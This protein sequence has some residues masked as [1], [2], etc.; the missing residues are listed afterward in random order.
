M[1]LRYVSLPSHIVLKN[2]IE[3]GNPVEVDRE[4]TRGK[5]TPLQRPN[6]E[7]RS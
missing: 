2:P 4:Q 3:Y 5:K 1:N 6:R 7:R